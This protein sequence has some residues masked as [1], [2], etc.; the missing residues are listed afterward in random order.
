MHIIQACCYHH[1]TLQVSLDVAKG[2][3]TLHSGGVIH[4]DLKPQVLLFYEHSFIASLKHEI[5]HS[6]L[7]LR[8]ALE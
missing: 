5:M 1:T 7:V 8:G 4:R 3:A 6:T 2:L